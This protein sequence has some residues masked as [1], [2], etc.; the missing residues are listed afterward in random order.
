MTTASTLK[1]AGLGV[2]TTKQALENLGKLGVSLVNLVK[3][4]KTGGSIGSLGKVFECV[5]ILKDLVE[6]IPAALPE[7]S[8]LEAQEVGEL[9]ATAYVQIKR[10]WDSVVAKQL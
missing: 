6:E 9:T 1:T 2:Q 3:T 4:T 7:L 10:V 8:D 5:M